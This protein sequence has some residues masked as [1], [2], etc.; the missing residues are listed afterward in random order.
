[1]GTQQDDDE[2]C[3]DAGR[4]GRRRQRDGDQRSFRVRGGDRREV[5]VRQVSC[6]LVRP[7]QEH[8]ASLGQAGQGVRRQLQHRPRGPLT[9][10][11]RHLKV[12]MKSTSPKS[13]LVEKWM[14][15][16]RDRAAV[17]TVCSHISNLSKGVTLGFRYK[18][19]AAYAHFPINCTVVDGGAT[20]EVRNFLGEKFLRKVPMA[21]GVTVEISKAQKDELYVNA[22]TSKMS[23]NLLH[24]FSSQQQLKTRISENSW[25]DSTSPRKQPLLSL[26][27]YDSSL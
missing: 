16:S 3:P 8:E 20:L 17:R 11:F 26:N 23:P 18:L 12:E 2:G 1:M 22:T 19:R 10:S 5:G 15:S 24:E 25:T 14:G 6:A 21:P 4:H 7:L 27:K 13:I 9:K